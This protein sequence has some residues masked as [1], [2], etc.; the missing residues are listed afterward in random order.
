[1]KHT[2]LVI[3]LLAFLFPAAALA[4]VKV[5]TTTA[6]L[7]DAARGVGGSRVE[8]KSI[9]PGFQDP[10]HVETKPSYLTL[11]RDA[12]VF[13]MTGLDLEVAWAPDLLRNARN[14]KIQPGAR[15]FLDASSGIKVLQKPAGQVDR[16]SGDIHPLGNPHYTMSPTNM[17]KVAR[18]VTAMLKAIDPAG[19]ATYDQ[20]YKDYWH[21]LDA[22]E[23][24]WK[25]KLA[26]YA[27]HK[28]VTYHSTWTYFAETFKLSVIGTIEPKPGI[29]PS[30]SYLDGLAQQMKSQGVK[31]II[32]EPWYPNNLL[33]AVARRSG[34]TVLRLPIQP[35]GVKGADTYIEMMD[36]VVNQL[37]AALK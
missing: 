33:D 20:G 5:V 34:A 31:V 2:L 1:V 22:A 8:V 25:Q 14:T 17:K 19:A 4:K 12:D 24:R 27:G 23:K 36:L 13:V 16:T 30:A 29:S 15:G 11:L 10:H 18:S 26:P 32:A 6:D 21:K 28:I 9:A 37:A 35:G 7:A 3:G